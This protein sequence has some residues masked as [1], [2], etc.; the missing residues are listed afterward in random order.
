MTLI[1]KHMSSV[2]QKMNEFSILTHLLSQMQYNLESTHI[3]TSEHGCTDTDMIDA[4]G[5]SGKYAKIRLYSLLEAYQQAIKP[6]G[7]LLK[8]NPL[9]GRWFLG[10]PPAIIEA[11]FSNP[12]QNKSRLAA[13]LMVIVS[14]IL[15]YQKPVEKARI[16]E[17]RNK[18]SIEDDLQELETMGFITISQST[19]SL[20]PRLGYFIDFDKFV[21]D[22][23]SQAIKFDLGPERPQKPPQGDS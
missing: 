20:H 9:N 22:L 8:K 10:K 13:T 19:V 21:S 1:L 16:K 12:F 11:T 3:N 6:F 5:F 18:Q 7:L 15:I 2:M 17:I 23:E 4:L 14:L